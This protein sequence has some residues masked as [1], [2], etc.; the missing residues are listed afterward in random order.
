[1]FCSESPQPIGYGAPAQPRAAGN[2]H[3][4]RFPSSMRIDDSDRSHTPTQYSD[5]LQLWILN[6]SSREE[7]E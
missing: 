7:K 1:V 2:D 6:P 4:C 3:A 5:C